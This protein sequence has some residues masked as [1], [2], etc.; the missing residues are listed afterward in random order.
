MLA[1]SYS[2]DTIYVNDPGYSTTSYTLSQIV[3]GQNGIYS[4]NNGGWYNWLQNLYSN[5]Y[6]G[7]VRQLSQER[8]LHSDDPV[9]YE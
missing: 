4:V 3:D 7:Y 1:Y 6:F 2:G 9:Q 5:L 8:V